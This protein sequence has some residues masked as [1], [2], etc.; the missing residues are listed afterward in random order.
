MAAQSTD[1]NPTGNVWKIPGN[2]LYISNN[3]RFYTLL[4]NVFSGWLKMI[5]NERITVADSKHVFVSNWTSARYSQQN[6]QNRNKEKLIIDNVLGVTNFQNTNPMRVINI[7]LCCGESM[8][9]GS[10]FTVS[11]VC[12]IHQLSICFRT[13]GKKVSHIWYS[14]FQLWMFHPTQLSWKPRNW[15]S[16]INE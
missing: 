15:R 12:I 8:R 4:S 14:T 6:T 9:E 13:A 11:W 1:L 5:F 2:F 7:K 3:F 10:D 16:K